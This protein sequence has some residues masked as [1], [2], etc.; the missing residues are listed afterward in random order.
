M[1]NT[2]I[3]QPINTN[4][5]ISTHT[6]THTNLLNGGK[7]DLTDYGKSLPS[8]QEIQLQLHALTDNPVDIV[9]NE[10]VTVRAEN[11]NLTPVSSGLFGL[12]LSYERID[13]K[14]YLIYRHTPYDKSI[15]MGKIEDYFIK[16]C[17]L[18][19]V[20]FDGSGGPQTP[21]ANSLI[22]EVI[23]PIKYSKIVF[24][25]ENGLNY[26]KAVCL[27][28][29]TTIINNQ[30]VYKYKGIPDVELA[31]LLASTYTGGLMAFQMF[32]FE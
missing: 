3:I 28:F 5:D 14:G 10:D 15:W 4:V 24:T 16:N 17:I 26:E 25:N 22:V 19:G 18:S 8:L 7:A 32:L 13:N 21:S 12:Q 20:I 9:V 6:H 2:K 27:F 29:E 11:K 30:V 31:R 1:K 23:S